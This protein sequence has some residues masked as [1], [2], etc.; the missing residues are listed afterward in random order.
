MDNGSVFVVLISVAVGA[1]LGGVVQTL[2]ARY[3]A[4]K[5]AQGIAVSVRAEI[6]ALVE[7][8]EARRYIECLDLIVDR[9][10]TTGNAMVSDYFSPRIKEDYFQVFKAVA[11]TIGMLKEAAGPSVKAYTLAQSFIE[12][13]HMLDENRRRVENGMANP[14]LDRLLTATR[15]VR[16]MLSAALI[17]GRE[18]TDALGGFLRKRWLGVFP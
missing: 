7:L 8:V 18:A 15:E 4:H 1:L 17:V 10:Q 14:N 12:D 5:E 13:V 6:N 2:V 9:L 16:E 11:P 3:A